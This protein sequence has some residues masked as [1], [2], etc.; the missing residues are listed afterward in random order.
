MAWKRPE[1]VPYPSVWSTFVGNKYPDMDPIEYKIQD[2]T[3]DLFEDT[4]KHMTRYFLVRENLCSSTGFSENEVSVKEMEDIWREKLKQKMGLV[5]LA[6]NHET[7][8]ETI[9]GVNMTSISHKSEKSSY[10]ELKGPV[11][12]KVFRSLKDLE[13]PINV[14]DHFNVEVYLTALGL[15]VAPQY[16]GENIGYQ[17]LMARTKLCQAT[18]LTLTVTAFSGPISQH[19]AKKAGFHVLSALDYETYKQ[20]GK[21]AFPKLKGD[22][23]LMAKEINERTDN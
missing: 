12:K 4:V 20:D 6:I 17:L 8:E 2:I 1:S 9:A 15:S 16:S 18:G 10:S 11:M 7:G 14:F 13:A 23:K 21:I 3:E 5:A 19:L 22:M